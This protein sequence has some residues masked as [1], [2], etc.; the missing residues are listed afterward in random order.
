MVL[1]QK[2]LSMTV[3]IRSRLTK[4]VVIIGAIVLFAVSYVGLFFPKTVQFSYNGPT[5]VPQLT[6]FP[7]I[8]K[9]ERNDAYELSI[10]DETKVFGY[11]LFAHSVCAQAIDTPKEGETRLSLAP[12]GWLIGKKNFIIKTAQH[13][14]VAINVLSQ[15]LVIARPL[16]L[17]LSRSDTIFTYKVAANQKIST[18]NPSGNA[19]LCNLKEVGMN[20]GG[21]YVLS[22]D[23][24]FNNK[25][26]ETIVEKSVKTLPATNI[27]GSSV[28]NEQTIYDKPALLT[29]TADKSLR[30]SKAAATVKVD[31][32]VPTQV[33]LVTEVNDKV[34]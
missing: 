32:K 6:V 7:K 33:S 11:P 18:C 3:W 34:V 2:L 25:K 26:V 8:L 20:Q 10:K 9:T 30:S 22:I 23:R 28:V 13:S 29:F 14:T 24:Y 31:D 17:D 27:V 16:K 5:C 4:K 19:V 1:K 15:P 12:F 21:E